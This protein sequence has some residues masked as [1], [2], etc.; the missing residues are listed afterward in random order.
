MSLLDFCLLLRSSTGVTVLDI[1][2]VW[3]CQSWSPEQPPQALNA[4]QDTWTG[5]QTCRVVEER[6]TLTR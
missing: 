2:Q 5:N 6:V 4:D 1:P 3:Q